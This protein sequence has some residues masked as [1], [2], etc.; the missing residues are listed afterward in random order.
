[1]SAINFMRDSN[2]TASISPERYSVTSTFRVPKNIANNAIIK[3][4]DRATISPDILLLVCSSKK[5]ELSAFNCSA[6]YGIVASSAI[7]VTIIAVV[8]RLP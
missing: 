7:K 1:M 6:I 2:A 5:L 8:W 4:A 3:V